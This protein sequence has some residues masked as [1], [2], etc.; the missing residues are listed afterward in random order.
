MKGRLPCSGQVISIEQK[1]NRGP[2]G[3]ELK[4]PAGTLHLTFEPPIRCTTTRSAA[5][6]PTPAPG[7]SASSLRVSRSSVWPRRSPTED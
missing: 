2:L 7:L 6:P 4:F 1:L 3:P 5:P